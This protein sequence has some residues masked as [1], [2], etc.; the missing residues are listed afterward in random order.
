MR[1]INQKTVYK[2]LAVPS[3]S[4]AIGFDQILQADVGQVES[5]AELA[6]QYGAG[7]SDFGT[8]AKN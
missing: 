7:E 5:D 3:T 2:T 1:K 8:W 4:I 6:F